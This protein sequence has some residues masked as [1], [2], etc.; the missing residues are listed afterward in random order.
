MAKRRGNGEGTIVRHEASRRW[1]GQI[2]VGR[3]P[4]SG[5][6]V[7]KTVYGDTQAEVRQKMDEE[8]QKPATAP[9]RQSVA[10]AIDFWL[11]TCKARVDRKTAGG[12]AY[13]I[14]PAKER[15]G[16]IPL[17][18]LT[19]MDVAELYRWM[20]ERGDS[21]DRAHRAGSRLRQ[22][23]AKCVKMDLLKVSPAARVDLPR[24]QRDKVNPMTAAQ[25][26]HLLEVAAGFTHPALFRLALDSGGRC[27][28]LL[29]L[30][31]DDVALGE[32]PEVFFNK[33]L[34][35]SDG[36]MRVKEPKTKASRR[37]VPLTRR[38]AD[39]LEA[40]RGRAGAADPVFPARNGAFIWPTNLF[41]VYW[42]PLREAA[43]LEEFRFHD[44]R[45]T[46]ATLLLLANVHPKVVQE[47]LGHAKI[48]MTLN[49]YSHLL[50]GMQT[51]AVAALET[52][53]APMAVER[54]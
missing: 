12:Y 6:R 18:D 41:R 13:D 35:V 36:E 5:K 7:R 40:T 23:L 21:P 22:C 16:R 27:G 3:H 24:V 46:C 32:A 52:A 9:S 44:L 47:R 50:P 49:T 30:T 29:A 34:Q 48:E 26:R 10:T 39:A 2:T 4:V 15:L 53:L 20:A 43:A 11:G 19:A 51:S 8:R 17:A 54:L 14:A 42:A 28:E 25:A 1:M 45:H 37:R 33:S 38:T 31:W